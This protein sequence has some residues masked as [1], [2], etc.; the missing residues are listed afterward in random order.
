MSTASSAVPTPTAS[1]TEIGATCAGTSAVAPRA[2]IAKNGPD[3]RNR[4]RSASS[5]APAAKTVSVSTSTT[6][7]TAR[8]ASTTP[9]AM[10]AHSST[11]PRSCARLRAQPCR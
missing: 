6:P 5:E 3:G 1:A 7:G 10:A 8:W 2:K 9:I 11:P 4:H